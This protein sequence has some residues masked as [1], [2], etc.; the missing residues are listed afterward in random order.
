MPDRRRSGVEAKLDKWRQFPLFDDAIELLQSLPR[1][2]NVYGRIPVRDENK[3]IISYETHS[4]NFVFPK[5]VVSKKDG[6]I[7]YF[8]VN[9]IRD[10]WKT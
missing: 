6:I 10:G 1:H 2:K 7:E 5:K 8:R 3:E 9:Y 4:A